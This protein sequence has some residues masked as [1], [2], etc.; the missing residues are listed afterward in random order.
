MLM[1]DLP[2]HDQVTLRPYPNYS[3]VAGA[4]RYL[5]RFKLPVDSGG[6]TL[7]NTQLKRFNSHDN[8]S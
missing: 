7:Y 6:K 8:H 5:N 2:F 1:G 4:A 3:R